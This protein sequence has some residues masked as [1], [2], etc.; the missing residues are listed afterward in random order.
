[1]Y[2]FKKAAWKAEAYRGFF[3][4]FFSKTPSKK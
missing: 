1:M 3:T 4:G 2:Q